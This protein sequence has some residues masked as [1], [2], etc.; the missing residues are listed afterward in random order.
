LTG[1]GG[2]SGVNPPDVGLRVSSE[3]VAPFDLLKVLGEG[4]NEYNMAVTGF[5]DYQP[6]AL[7][8]RDDAGDIRGG[9]WGWVWAQWLYVANLFVEERL[10]GRGWG[11]QLLAAAEDEARLAGARNAYLETYSFQARPFYEARG[12]EVTGE[13]KD[14]PPGGVY[15]VMRKAL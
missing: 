12:Y 4:N 3:P 8:L 11:A 10:R 2:E 9:I 7:L 14:L 15:Y 1:P 5:R 13:I 6:V